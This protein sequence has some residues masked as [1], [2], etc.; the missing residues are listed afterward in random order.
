VG[1]VFFLGGITEVCLHLP[2]SHLVLE[3]LSLGVG[4]CLRAKT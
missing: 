2:H 3:L 4:S 1:V